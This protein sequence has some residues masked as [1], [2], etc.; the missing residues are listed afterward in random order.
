MPVSGAEFRVLHLYSIRAVKNSGCDFP[1]N[2]IACRRCRETLCSVF[3]IEFR[4]PK[5]N[6]AG[7]TPVSRS[8]SNQPTSPSRQQ[9]TSAVCLVWWYDGELRTW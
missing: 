2:S 5:L 9:P 4:F 7:S 3:S 1:V 6:V 8:I